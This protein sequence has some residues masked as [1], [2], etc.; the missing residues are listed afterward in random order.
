MNVKPKKD[1]STSSIWRSDGLEQK[2]LEKLMKSGKIANDKP[3]D[4]QKNMLGCLESF[5]RQFFVLIF[6]GRKEI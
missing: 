4:V 2:E 1:I 6:R 5:R 3:S